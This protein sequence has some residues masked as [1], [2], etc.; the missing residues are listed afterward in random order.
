MSTTISKEEIL[1]V[2]AAVVPLD[3]YSTDRT[4]Q[5]TDRRVENCIQIGSECDSVEITISGTGS[6]AN[7]C[8]FNIYGYV[9]AGPALR[10]LKSGTATLGRAI[11]GE[12]Q[13]FAGSIDGKECHTEDVGIH[14]SG[15]DSIAKMVFDTQGHKY[16]YFELVSLTKMTAVKFRVRKMG[17]I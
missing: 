6:R 15:G 9:N 14:D 8:G 11:A 4:F 1:S 10:I 3:G 2:T 17:L 5:Y 7:S 13:L 12:G 16:L